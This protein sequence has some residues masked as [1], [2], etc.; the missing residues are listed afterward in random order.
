MGPVLRVKGLG[1]SYSPGVTALAGIDLEAWSGEIVA[2]VGEN[3]SGKTTLFKVIAGLLH[4][5]RGTVEI[6][7]RD[8]ASMSVPEI[9]RLAGLVLQNPDVQLF[10]GTVR[11]E[12]AFGVKNAGLDEEQVA[13]A[14][15]EAIRVTGLEGL[16][17]EF[18]LALSRGMRGRVALASA[19]AMNPPVLMLDEPT[20]GQDFN[21]LRRIA[22]ILRQF[23]TMGGAALIAT[24]NLEFVAE[25]AS[26]IVV[27]ESG[28]I[29]MNGPTRW[30]MSLPDL[31]TQVDIVL[32]QVVRLDRGLFSGGRPVSLTVSE[33]AD[34]V[35]E[36]YRLNT[37]QDDA[38]EGDDAT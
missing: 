18:P 22:D 13:R 19:L 10:S 30:L 27:M 23:A 32:P 34:K 8:A 6:C 1:Y 14:T 11:D 38:G 9:A 26:R 35:E 4:P 28:A 29:R 33:L 16:E 5:Y 2:I 31:L 21:S 24:H 7:G 25:N 15:Q 37:Q 12:V 36:E 3:G 20:T 17:E